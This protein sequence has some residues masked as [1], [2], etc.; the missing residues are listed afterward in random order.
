MFWL[1]RRGE[2]QYRSGCDQDVMLG[3]V[4]KRQD[5][6][7]AEVMEGKLSNGQT[8]DVYASWREARRAIEDTFSRQRGSA[9][10]PC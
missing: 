5:G 1:V 7:V 8:K 4:A 10:P 2:H 9:M 3:Y 6:W